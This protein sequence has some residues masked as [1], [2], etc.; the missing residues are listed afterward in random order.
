MESINFAEANQ[1]I[2]GGGLGSIPIH[3]NPKTGRATACFKLTE[4]EVARIYATGEIYLRFNTQGMPF[5]PAITKTCI[6]ERLLK[7]YLQESSVPPNN[8]EED[9]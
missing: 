8:Q 9:E 4:E 5:F 6:K 7:G 1:T 2:G 3:V